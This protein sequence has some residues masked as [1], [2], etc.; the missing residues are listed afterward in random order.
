MAPPFALL[1]TFV[2]VARAVRMT[3][4]AETL[5]V[6]PGA[7]TQR[8]QTLEATVGRSLLVRTPQGVR[9]T[10][11]GQSLFDRLTGPFAEIEGAYAETTGR[12]RRQ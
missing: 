11:A 9:L 6:T 2:L 12:G 4:A 10:R 8:V 3:S 1:H 5:G 7:I